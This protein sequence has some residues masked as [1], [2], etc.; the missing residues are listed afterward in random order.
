MGSLGTTK[1][2]QVKY[3]RCLHLFL[4]K[5]DGPKERKLKVKGKSIAQL[6]C[7]AR[8]CVPLTHIQPEG[9]LLTCDE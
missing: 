4:D 6:I 3:D 5:I 8:P 1:R 7:M 2:D 9:V